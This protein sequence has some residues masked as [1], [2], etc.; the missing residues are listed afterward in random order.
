MKRFIKEYAS[1]Q[2]DRFNNGYYAEEPIAAIAIKK[3]HKVV[4]LC[5]RGAVTVDEAV[6]TILNA[7]TLAEEEFYYQE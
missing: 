6:Y 4:S 1:Y 3:I 2:I 7:R 5:E